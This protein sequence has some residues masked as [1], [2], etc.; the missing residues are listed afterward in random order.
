MKSFV[1]LHTLLPNRPASMSVLSL[2]MKNFVR[3]PVP[4]YTTLTPLPIEGKGNGGGTDDDVPN[5]VLGQVMTVG[6]FTMI[7]LLTLNDD[8]VFQVAKA[9]V[10]G[11]GWT[12]RKPH[13]WTD[14][15]TGP[16]ITL[17]PAMSKYNGELVKVSLGPM[18]SFTDVSRWVA[19][20]ATL[21]VKFK[22][23]YD[24]HVSVA[25]QRLQ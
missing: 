3:T 15:Q 11:M 22:C 21:P 16:H 9:H 13:A 24:C 14:Y 20:K 1:L 5:V 12:V 2:V 23:P 4:V 6:N 25:Q 7:R 17:V 18:Y 8:A 19:Y 10:S